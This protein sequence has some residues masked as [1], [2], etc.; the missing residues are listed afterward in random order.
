MSKYVSK[1]NQI[2]GNLFILALMAITIY[3]FLR[4]YTI[5]E[6]I[7][8]LKNVR[9]F[10]LLAGLSMMVLYIV[11][12]A[13]IFNMILEV[14][15]QPVSFRSCLEYS[16]IGYYFGSITPGASGGQPAQMYYMSK[17]K[18]PV[19]CSSITV[20]L[21][22]FAY[23]I[24][25]VLFSGLMTIL[26]FDIAVQVVSKLN[27]LLIIGSVI[28]VGIIIFLFSAMY[29]RKM[30]PY[31]MCLGVKLGEK[32]HLVKNPEKIHE[33]LQQTINS[34]HDKSD[35][36]SKHPILLIK[37]LLV[38]LVELAA[39]NMVSYL[40]Y[41]GMGYREYGALNLM[42]SQSLLNISLAAVPLPGSV[43]VAEDVFLKIFSTYY[44]AEVLP[45][46]MILSRVV[47]FYLPLFI[48]FVVYLFAH[49]RIMKHA[50]KK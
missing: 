24:A 16:Y 38:T 33:K 8:V 23:Q 21:M 14:F 36:L 11:C 48:S 37:V 22:V 39:T 35:V 2:K 26:R 32:L 34:Y 29:S 12:Q 9:P 6:L 10:Y 44:P 27:Y 45:S 19:A 40:V 18:I 7:D 49:V 13:I 17:D 3:A 42:T 4:G 1:K 30:V 20:F 50:K 25:M 5:G 47:N 15:K 43:G 46:A 28:T 41:L 31:L